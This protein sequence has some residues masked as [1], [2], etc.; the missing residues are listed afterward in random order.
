MTEIGDGQFHKGHPVWVIQEGGSQREAEYVGEGET[1]AWFGG[2]PTV[3]VVYPDTH[4][5]AAVQVDRV[6]PRDA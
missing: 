5:G 3:I 1:S 4:T 6:I 2:P